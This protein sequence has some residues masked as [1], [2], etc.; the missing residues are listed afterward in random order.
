MQPTATASIPPPADMD[1]QAMQSMDWLFK[2]ERIYLLA[3]FWQ[4]RAT[5]AEKEVT[6]LKEQLA[7]SNIGC[8]TKEGSM[9]KPNFET[10]I[11]AK[12]KEVSFFFFGLL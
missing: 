1:L 3:Q 8:E 4:Q 12:D 2:K 6:T 10:E 11:A 9:E 5:L 7:S